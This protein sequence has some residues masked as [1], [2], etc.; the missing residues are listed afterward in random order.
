[1]RFF[2]VND[3]G[4]VTAFD[5]VTMQEFILPSYM[6]NTD[7][8]PPAPPKDMAYNE[9]G[10]Q[11]P[12]ELASS[13]PTFV[14]EAVRKLEIKR[15]RIMFFRAQDACRELLTGL[16]EWI[17]GLTELE[18]VVTLEGAISLDGLKMQLVPATWF[19]ALEKE[20]LDN[21]SQSMELT[22]TELLDKCIK[23]C[24]RELDTLSANSFVFANFL[25]QITPNHSD[26]F[27]K[28]PEHVKLRARRTIQM[29]GVVEDGLAELKRAVALLPVY[30]ARNQRES[31]DLTTEQ[32]EVLNKNLVAANP[33][34]QL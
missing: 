13:D 10:L 19:V 20:R 33:S 5:T 21:V 7:D 31:G 28:L 34:L 25:Q 22:L 29:K 32:P 9:I 16:S 6:S 14:A 2:Q 24:E 17:A 15:C 26:V 18:K 4:M 23:R 30:Y 8:T 12:V 1:M 11:I 3:E 27:Q